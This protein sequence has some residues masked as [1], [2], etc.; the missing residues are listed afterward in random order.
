MEHEL[1]CSSLLGNL[2]VIGLG[3]QSVRL[4]GISGKCFFVHFSGATHRCHWSLASEWARQRLPRKRRLKVAST[5]S[6]LAS[7]R[8]SLG[9][10]SSQ[11][12]C[13][14]VHSLLWLF[15]G[16]GVSHSGHHGVLLISTQKALA[17]KGSKWFP[18]HGSTVEQA[19]L[20]N[21][22]LSSTF[23]DPYVGEPRRA[24]VAIGNHA[25][26]ILS[27]KT[28][29]AGAYGAHQAHI[30]RPP[31]SSYCE[32]GQHESSVTNGG[33]HCKRESPEFLTFV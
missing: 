28:D 4:G 20:W 12:S 9:R 7:A 5:C 26:K 8:S 17:L 11:V 10:F 18:S 6:R 3:V 33:W 30:R 2:R 14:V 16:S 24:H 23:T 32:S 29:K 1:R 25:K 21:H 19:I 27:P 31:A 13:C 22:Q 15:R